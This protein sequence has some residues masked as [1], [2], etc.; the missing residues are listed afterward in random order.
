MERLMTAETQSGRGGFT[1]LEVTIAMVVFAIGMLA[2]SGM[3]LHALQ[4][5]SRGRHTTQATSLAEVYMEQLQQ[6]SWTQLAPTAGWAAPVQETNTVQAAQGDQNEATYGV[7]W[8]ITDLV[9][10]WTRTIDVRVTW[11]EP[12]RSGRSVVLE[13]IRFNR[14]GL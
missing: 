3:L 5:G 14:E 11:D 6:K 1:L 8:Q 13:S 7:D 2:L 9:P 12:G 4:G 10:G